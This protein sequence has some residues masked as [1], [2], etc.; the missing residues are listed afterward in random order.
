MLIKISKEQLLKRISK[1]DHGLTNVR[2]PN[3]KTNT[4]SIPF[5][6]FAFLC[7]YMRNDTC[8]SL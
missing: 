2:I 7:L 1:E 4:Q 8:R 6:V 3:G 5:E